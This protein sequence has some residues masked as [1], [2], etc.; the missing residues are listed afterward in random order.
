LE[1]ENRAA[2]HPSALSPGL[3]TLRDWMWLL[4]GIVVLTAGMSHY[5]AVGYYYGWRA[6]MHACAI[7][8]LNE[9][10]EDWKS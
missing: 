9:L 3:P 7:A 8:A 2:L 1:L 4:I 10:K 5:I 6:G